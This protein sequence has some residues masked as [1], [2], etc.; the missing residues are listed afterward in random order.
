VRGVKVS[1]N[2]DRCISSGTCADLVPQVFELR[3]DGYLYVIQEEPG[4]ELRG[5]VEE[6]AEMCPTNAISIEG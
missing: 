4:E 5:A 6:A 1:V 2:F 3:D